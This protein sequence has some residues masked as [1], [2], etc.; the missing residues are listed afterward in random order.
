MTRREYII[1]TLTDS[2]IDLLYYDRKEDESFPKGGIESAI[3]AGEI[4]VD[5]MIEVWSGA[6]RD[7]LVL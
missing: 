7:G 6:L 5:E 2:I 3:T 4:T 1:A